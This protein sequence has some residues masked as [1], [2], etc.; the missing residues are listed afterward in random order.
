MYPRSFFII[1]SAFFGTL[2]I[3]SAMKSRSNYRN[4]KIYEKSRYETTADI[5]EYSEY[6]EDRKKYSRLRIKYYNG[7]HKPQKRH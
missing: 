1:L 6:S 5:L 2:S 4:H 3:L 7:K